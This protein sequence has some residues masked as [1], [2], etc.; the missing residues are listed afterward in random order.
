MFSINYTLADDGKGHEKLCGPMHGTISPEDN[1]RHFTET[2]DH[3]EY[4][5]ATYNLTIKARVKPV[6]NV[7]TSELWSDPRSITFETIS[8]M[9]NDAPETDVGAFYADSES[10]QVYLYWEPLPPLKHSGERLRY[11]V[12]ELS[13]PSLPIN[14]TWPMNLAI[15]ADSIE[16]NLEFKFRSENDE[17]ISRSES[18]LNVPQLSR[19]CPKPFGLKL[20]KHIDGLYEFSWL[21]VA[22]DHCPQ[23]TSYTIFWCE[24]TQ[25]E[26]PGGCDGSVTFVRVSSD[27]KRF[28]LDSSETLNFAV[29]VNTFNSSSGM[30]WAKC[31]AFEGTHLSKL[32]TIRV[33]RVESTVIEYKW[34]LN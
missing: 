25:I 31:V 7:S 23:I 21:S 24:I 17:G 13:R 16:E 28:I 1:L 33:V 8:R 5:H 2:I 10:H 32:N 11:V 6:A 34:Q 22:S 30:E 9:P 19:R 27:D 14:Y 4:A 12:T 3:L 18:F 15:Y 29:S 20:I 26:L